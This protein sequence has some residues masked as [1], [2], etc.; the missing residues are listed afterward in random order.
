MSYTFVF[1]DL[2]EFSILTAT[3]FFEPVVNFHDVLNKD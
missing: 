2:D 3:L 1:L